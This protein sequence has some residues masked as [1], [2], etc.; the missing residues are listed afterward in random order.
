MAVVC[1]TMMWAPRLALIICFY[2]HRHARI[3]ALG[4]MQSKCSTEVTVSCGKKNLTFL[5]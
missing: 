5:L 3:T 1:S 2:A 4:I